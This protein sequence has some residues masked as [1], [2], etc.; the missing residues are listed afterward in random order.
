MLSERIEDG[1]SRMPVLWA[2]IEDDEGISAPWITTGLLEHVVL[3]AVAAA[4]HPF[5]NIYSGSPAHNTVAH[6]L[7]IIVI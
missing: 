3:V 4:S 2:R 5:E 7:K 6:P 1:P